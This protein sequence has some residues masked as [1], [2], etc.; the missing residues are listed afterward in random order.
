MLFLRV[1]AAGAHFH[2]GHAV[3]VR[4]GIMLV[5]LGTEFAVWP[6]VTDQG[7]YGYS[8]IPGSVAEPDR[9]I[10]YEREILSN[11]YR[12]AQVTV[13]YALQLQVASSL[14]MFLAVTPGRILFHNPFRLADEILDMLVIQHD[15]IVGGGR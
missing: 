9:K 13:G 15:N 3:D 2:L 14:T 11:E 12:E 5:R 4:L 8:K 10:L 6:V 1:S 7:N